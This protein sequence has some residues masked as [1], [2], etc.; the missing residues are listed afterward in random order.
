MSK[1]TIFESVIRGWLPNPAL[2]TDGTFFS[3]ANGRRPWNSK[4]ILRLGGTAGLFWSLLTLLTS[5]GIMYVVSRSFIWYETINLGLMF[6]S[7]FFFVGIYLVFIRANPIRT[8][9]AAALG[10]GGNLL[11][12]SAYLSPQILILLHSDINFPQTISIQKLYLALSISGSLLLGL[13]IVLVGTLISIVF[14]RTSSI[15]AGVLAMAAGLVVLGLQLPGAA[16]PSLA[17]LSE[18]IQSIPQYVS[19]I[20]ILMIS[21]SFLHLSKAIDWRIGLLIIASGALA[22]YLSIVGLFWLP[23]LL[24]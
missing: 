12:F 1:R 24:G 8:W 16:F 9:I 14:F 10:I 18:T 5:A 11:R 21:V 23:R 3:H 17:Q 6:T 20:W 13:S 2:E 19:I 15:F 7:I 4:R 22:D